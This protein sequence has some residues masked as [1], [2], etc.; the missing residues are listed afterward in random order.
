[1]A[2]NYDIATVSGSKTVRTTELTGGHALHVFVAQMPYTPIGAPEKLTVG[3]GAVVTLSPPGTATHA[4]LVV[5]NNTVRYYEDGSTP[6]TG[7][8][9]NGPP[10]IAGSYIEL[11]LVLFST[12]KMIG[13]TGTATVHVLYRKYV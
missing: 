10:L 9:G 1:M 8:S 12:F 11:D 7:S 13:M 3:T 2:N 5:E 6:T 4:M